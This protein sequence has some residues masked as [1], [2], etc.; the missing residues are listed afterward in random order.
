[1]TCPYSEPNCTSDIVTDAPRCLCGR[2][3]KRCSSCSARNRAFAIYCRGCGAA[4]PPSGAHWTGYRGGSRRLGVNDAN[5][6]SDCITRPTGLQLRL[7]D[8]CRSL[9]GDDGHV[10]A[11]SLSGVVEIADPMRAKSVCRFQAQGPITA[12]PCISGGVLYLATRGQVSAYALAA[13]TMETPRVR[14]LWHV[15]L[16]GTPIQALTPVGDRLYVTVATADW[17][18]VHIIEGQ[19]ARLLYGAPKLSWL[20]ADPTS[21]QA[22]FLSEERG[23]VQVHVVGSELATRPVPLQAIAEH[24][25]AFLGGA[26][27]GIFGDAHRLYRIDAATGEVEE[28]LEED[29]QFFALTHDGDDWNRDSV[30]IDSSGIV[31]SRSGVR[32]AFA[33]HER[34][35]RGSPVIVEGCAVAVGMEDGRVLIYHAAHLPHHEIWRLG[36]NS[37]AAITALAAF[38]SYLAAGNKD[39]IVEVRALLAK[40]T[41]R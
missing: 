12:E 13:M 24:P 36:E 41:P 9:L 14:P 39:G 30:R 22:V 37:G 20:A 5:L 17:R 16:A 10:V 28:P 40:G 31:F 21:A 18:E 8:S 6:D 7:G 27:F 29:T 2:Y 32:D 34:A 23:F 25:I 33:P 4:L 15:P 38:D 26:I 1:V 3:V 11:V 35:V 19:A